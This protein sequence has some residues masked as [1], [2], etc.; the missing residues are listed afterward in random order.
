MTEQGHSDKRS[1]VLS[2]SRMDRAAPPPH[3]WDWQT[4][5]SWR[6]VVW[7]LLSDVIDDQV[8]GAFLVDPPQCVAGDDL[9]WL[10]K[11][12]LKAR[13]ETVDSKA[14]LADRLV[15]RFTHLRAVHGTRTDDVGSFYK[16]GLL[17]LDPE[18]SHRNVRRIFLEGMFPEL[19]AGDVEEAIAAVGHTYRAGRVYFEANE[20]MFLEQCG[21]Y[22]HY[23]SE[24][25][26]A[27]AAH[28]PGS[29]DYRQVLK[30]EGQP[31][32]FVCD[33]P[34]G[35]VSGHTVLEF[36]GMALSYIF[37]DLLEGNDYVPDPWR[38]AGFAI[39]YPLPPACIVGHYHPAHVRDPLARRGVRAS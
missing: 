32:L 23:G 33:V 9:S 34:L 2:P 6:G 4:Y 3:V 16:H 12:I 25:V 18:F 35:L 27:I 10:D 1:G 39:R 14:L 19:T 7:D 31:T 13:G 11:I 20:P 26:T 38:G 30:K 15:H 8:R 37:E 24:Y 22:L 36:S 21:H 29:R 17:P 5:K 28:L